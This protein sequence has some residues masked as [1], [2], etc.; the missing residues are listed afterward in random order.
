M[1]ESPGSS[2]NIVQIKDNSE[3]LELLDEKD[4]VIDP[5]YFNNGL[6]KNS[7]I[8][9]RKSVVSKL[10]EARKSLPEGYNFKIF[11]GYRVLETQ[12]KLFEGLYNYYREH[13][14]NWSQKK[15]HEAT[16]IFVAVPSYDATCPSP[17]NT[18]GAVDLTIIDENG[19]EL[20]MGTEFDEFTEKAYTDHFQ[21]GE[22]YQNR[23]LLKDLMEKF[24][25]VNCEEEWWHYSFGDQMWASQ[26]GK[27]HAIYGSIEL[28]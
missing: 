2:Y 20:P 5:I 15:L 7:E 22:F 19:D 13:H 14:P 16:K 23:K 17:H 11:D 25:F 4:F 12:T 24:E 26:K 9:L 6:S 21:S 28:N 1:S 3:T 27:N 10:K 8:K 18:G